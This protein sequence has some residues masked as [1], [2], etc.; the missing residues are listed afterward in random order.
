[1]ENKVVEIPSDSKAN[2]ECPSCGSRTREGEN[3]CPACR[4]DLDLG[5]VIGNLHRID[6]LIKRQRGGRFLHTN[7]DAMK[8][9]GLTPFM[10][11]KSIRPQLGDNVH[12]T[13]T[14]LRF[15]SMSCLYPQF[16]YDF[17]RI[18]KLLGYYAINGLPNNMLKFMS[19]LLRKSETDIL[20]S[21]T[22]QKIFT[23]GWERLGGGILEFTDYDE[24]R[25]MLTYRVSKSAIFPPEERF[26]QP[27]CFIQLGAL[28]GLIEATTGKFCDGVETK[29]A[30][31]GDHCCE[32]NIYIQE[33]EGNSRFELLNKEQLEA[34]LDFVIS[35]LIKE[36]GNIREDGGDYVHISIDQGI[37]YMML[38]LSKGH[39]VLSKWSGRLLGEKLVNLK[40]IKNLFDALDYIETLFLNLKVGVMRKKILPDVIKVRINESLYSSGVRKINMGLCVFLA[41]IIEGVLRRSS[42]MDWLVRE[43]KCIA[44]GDGFC[45]FE[46]KTSDSTKLKQMLLG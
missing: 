33:D 44:N 6:Y 24:T 12:V 42:N 36:E 38:S 23:Q 35:K 37:N 20:M 10:E 11:T 39:I 15:L 19:R 9:M 43:T 5:E 3:R 7:F 27:A 4:F 34:S 46:C 25:R 16:V 8:L 17:Y 13:F 29:C 41:G 40:E 21:K 2:I 1:M 26:N 18:G 45:E 31:M 32:F 30:G 14:V 22:Y 28:C